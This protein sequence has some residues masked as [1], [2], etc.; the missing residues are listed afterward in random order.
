MNEWNDLDDPELKKIFRKHLLR[1][2]GFLLL[3][4]C[5]IFVLA[6]SFE[7]QIRASADWLTE[8]FGFAGLSFVVFLSDIIISPIPPDAALFFIGKS[9]MHSQW[10]VWVPLLGLISSLAGICGWMV[11]HK[12]QH[13]RMVKKMMIRFT[14]ENKGAIKRFGFWM[15]VIGAFTPLPFSLTCWVAGIIKLPLQTFALAALM[16]VP[17]FVLYYWAIFYSGEIGS[18]LRSLIGA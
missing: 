2:L 4:V 18:M 1:G 11:G 8:H 9:Q 13:L 15:V 12:L 16:R 3:L 10:I 14:R 5:F 7:P 6:L 17:R